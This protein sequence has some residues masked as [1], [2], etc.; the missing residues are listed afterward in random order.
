MKGSLGLPNRQLTSDELVSMFGP[1]LV[2]V[3]NELKR[4]SGG[5]E[6]LQWALRRKLAKELSYEERGKPGHRRQLKAFKRG[7]QGNKCAQCSEVLPAANVVLDRLEAML[8]YTKENTQLLCKDCD[9]KQQQCRGF[10]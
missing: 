4:L 2:H 6:R 3:R 7:E 9:Y 5:D 1:L 10:A 8:G